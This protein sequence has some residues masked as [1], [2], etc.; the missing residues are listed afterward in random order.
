VA[1]EDFGFD[2]AGIFR[3]LAVEPAVKAY[4]AH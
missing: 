1:N 3:L 2:V 4:H